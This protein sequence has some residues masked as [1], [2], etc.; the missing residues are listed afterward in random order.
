MYSMISMMPESSGRG[1]RLCWPS[2]LDLCWS[3]PGLPAYRCPVAVVAVF[4]VVPTRN[5]RVAGPGY[6]PV[7]T[8]RFRPYSH[9]RILPE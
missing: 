2:G 1:C 9:L 3:A 5:V 8:V 7:I 6:R 4:G